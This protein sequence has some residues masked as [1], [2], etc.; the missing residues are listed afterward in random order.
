MKLSE[1][2]R[3]FEEIVMVPEGTVNKGT[4][5]SSLDDWDSLSRASL[6]N[7]FEEQLNLKLEESSLRNL[8]KFQEI[9]DLLGNNIEE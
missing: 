9:V 3:V 1:F 5:L 8:K 7:Y 4:E 2:I 6:L